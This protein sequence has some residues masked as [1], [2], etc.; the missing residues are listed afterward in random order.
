MT[1]IFIKNEYDLKFKE[2]II[3]NEIYSTLKY[4]IAFCIFKIISYYFQKKLLNKNLDMHNYLFG[5]I[6][7]IIAFI[8]CFGNYEINNIYN[9][10]F[11]ISTGII[12][13][14]GLL[15]QKSIEKLSL[16]YFLSFSFFINVP[17][18]LNFSYFSETLNL[19]DV[20]S[21]IFFI[22]IMFLNN[23]D[24]CKKKKN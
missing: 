18:S 13:Y 6:N 20:L 7:S 22:Y 15:F 11:S 21:S 14:L 19:L 8:F 9:I 5:F 16:S 1:G 2:N 4:S 23:L 10:I 12:L 3:E 24:Y 17:I